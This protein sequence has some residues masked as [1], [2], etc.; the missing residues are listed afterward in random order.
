M[1]FY[2]NRAH[3]LDQVTFRI[4]KNGNGEYDYL[5]PWSFTSS[6]GRFEMDFE[7]I[8]DRHA[9]MNL[10]VLASFQH[11]V[12]GRFTGS[13]VLDDGTAIRI[14][15]FLGFAERV[16]NRWKRNMSDLLIRIMINQT[17]QSLSGGH[18][19]QGNIEFFPCQR[20]TSLKLR[21]TKQRSKRSTTDC[22]AG[23]GEYGLG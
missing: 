5:K 20:R 1:L 18:Y 15:N 2:N 11:Q 7:P 21:I 19:E 23:D 12:F 9:D 16:T 14:E 10:L 17:L 4:P 6:D 8:L 22:T 13:A 3:K